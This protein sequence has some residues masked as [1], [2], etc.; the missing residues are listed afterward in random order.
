MKKT[1][2]YI[3]LLSWV[4]IS[5]REMY[6]PD[7][8]KSPEL[9][10]VIQGRILANQPPEVKLYWAVSFGDDQVRVISDAEVYILDDYGF[11][12]QLQLH[13]GIYT[14]GDM[15]GEV[16]V[17]YTLRVVLNDGREY[18]S[19]PQYLQVAPKIDSLY[20]V[21]GKRIT[22]VYSAY[23]TP[24]YNEEQG[25][26][27]RSDLT[28]YE[29]NTQYYKFHTFVVKLS[30]YQEAINTPGPYNVYIWET[31]GMDNSYA[32]DFSVDNNSKQVL[33]NHSVGFLRYYYDPSLRTE[34]KTA[35]FTSAWVVTQTIYS[36]SADVYQFYNSVGRQLSAN[37]QIFAPVASQVKSNIHCISDSGEKVIGKFEASSATIIYKVFGWIDLNRYNSMDLDYYPEVGDGSVEKFPPDFWLYF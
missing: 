11:T 30:S 17:T 3:I 29:S 31:T 33:C 15:A 21:P 35:P 13:D 1:G 22:Y 14:T 26:F 2:M 10:P 4:L 18:V 36:I 16:G 6:Y 19:I 8:V 25:L 34:S 7:D 27:I 9:I 5:C 37:D 20:A 32:V 28:S 12:V 24:V 23:N